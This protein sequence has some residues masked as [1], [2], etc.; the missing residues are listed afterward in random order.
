[1]SEL[2]DE[3]YP[4]FSMIMVK[5]FQINSGKMGLN[6]LEH[7]FFSLK[8]KGKDM[9]KFVYVSNDGKTK[10]EI[11]PDSGYGRFTIRDADFVAFIQAKLVKMVKNNELHTNTPTLVVETIEFLEFC[12]RSKGGQ[13]FYNIADMLRRLGG[14]IIESTRDLDD[15]KEKKESTTI[16]DPE[17]QAVSEKV[18]DI[19]GKSQII[20]FQ[21][22]CR[23]WFVKPIRESNDYLTIPREYFRIKNDLHRR[24]WQIARMHCGYPG[25]EFSI[26]WEKLYNKVGTRQSLTTFRSKLRKEIKDKGGKLDILKY[27]ITQSK[28][29]RIV[30]FQPFRSVLEVKKNDEANSKE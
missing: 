10:I 30:I 23:E 20:A 3:Q 2:D 6:Y 26:T 13:S 25:K 22:K 4:Q 29:K 14:T 1:V 17:W 12:N 15:S 7:P 5:D 18:S 8:S 11:R 24:L 21:I 19:N 27:A 9:T 28:D 16:I